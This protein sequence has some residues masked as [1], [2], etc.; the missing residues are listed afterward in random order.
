MARPSRSRTRDAPAAGRFRPAPASAATSVTDGNGNSTVYPAGRHGR[1]VLHGHRSCYRRSDRDASPAVPHGR[2]RRWARR[3]LGQ[4]RAA[5]C[6]SRPAPTADLAIIGTGNALS[7]LGLTGNT[8][9]GT[10]FTAASHRGAWQPLR[11][12]L[13]LH[14]L[15]RRH[16]GQRHLRRRFQRHGQDPRPAQCRAAGQQPE[17]RRSNSTG[18][19]T[20]STSNDY[21]SSTLGS[22]DGRRCD[23]RHADHARSPSRPRRLRWSTLRRR[24]SAATW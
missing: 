20:I 6:R 16:G 21:A 24:P 10:S 17:P 22:R 1:R 2:E 7:A 4:L 23:R 3:L 12:D 15:Q 18:K 19:L 14:L 11:Q 9:T 5:R 8:G 13:D